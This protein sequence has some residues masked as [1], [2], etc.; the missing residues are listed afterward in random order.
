MPTASLRQQTH[1]N[2]P[3]DAQ[4]WP[5]AAGLLPF[6]DLDRAGRSALDRGPEHWHDVF[7][8]VLA[9]GFDSA[10]LTDTWLKVADLSPT[11][12]DE[13]ANIAYTVGLRLPAIALIRRSV[14]DVTDG[15]ANLVYSHR[16]IDAAAALGCRV[17]SVGLHEPLT[18]DQ[19]R[20]L[21]FWTE[22]G[23]TNDP[24][25]KDRWR[26]AVKRLRELGQHAAD[27]GVLL[28]LEMYEDTYLG[29]ADS[30]VRLVEDIDEPSVGLNPD[31]GNMLRLHRPVEP[32]LDV[33]EKT[34]P[35]ANY[36]HVKNYTRDEDRRRQLF[37]SSPSPMAFG[38]IDYRT[39][40]K[41][42]VDVGFR[43]VITCEHYG[44]D[45][46]TV[47]AANRDYL[48]SI[49]PATPVASPIL[50]SRTP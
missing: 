17:V 32:P 24:G 30:A 44:G 27:V 47:C 19:Q 33:L 8:E 23:P 35:Y 13:L 18:P 28:T 11:G 49:L 20:A 50:E 40:I 38:A 1:A 16:A 46:L 6:R 21:W 48:R 22:D 43:G 3:L 2:L 45:G 10:E 34:L 31:T 41:T 7:T 37:T 12:L 5:I 9:V 42:A 14:I 26:L 4:T 39:A 36:W 29:T 25:D 15:P